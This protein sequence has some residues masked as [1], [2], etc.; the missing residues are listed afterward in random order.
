MYFEYYLIGFVILVMLMSA[1]KK[2][3]LKGLLNSIGAI[4]FAVC[5][6]LG[7]RSFWFEPFNIPSGSMI[8]TLEIGDHL[9]ISKYS[10]GYTR[11]SF[12]LS[13]S[14][15]KGI[16]FDKPIKRGDI[17]VFR[18]PDNLKVDFIKR[19]VALPGEKVQMKGGTLYINGKKVEKNYVGEYVMA[20][21]A[22][23]WEG[24]PLPTKA[25]NRIVKV[26]KNDLYL[27]GQKFDNYTINYSE[28]YNCMGTCEPFVLKKY[29]ETL[30]NGVS[31]FVIE[32]SDMEALDNT[33]EVVIPEGQYF[34][35]GD[36]RDFSGDSRVFGP[37][38]KEN[39]IGKA[40]F[41]FFSH[42]HR[43]P[44]LSWIV[45]PFGQL[46]FDRFFDKIQD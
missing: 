7:V 5:L 26:V 8:P 18:N 34:M 30:P 40:R 22:R 15:F 16:W 44:F 2:N 17:V 41:I 25:G 9:F 39:V 28:L 38:N 23:Q 33:P 12:P 1:Y 29:K 31:Y 13:P 19:V 37:V 6:A 27:D 3:N 4:A 10:Y 43:K 32:K 36:D 24:R 11:F 45:W 21:L 14:F 35:M 46:R 42:N 20:D